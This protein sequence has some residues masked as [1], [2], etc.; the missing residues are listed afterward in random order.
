MS[1]L[2]VKDRAHLNRLTGYLLHVPERAVK[3]RLEEAMPWGPLRLRTAIGDLFG[4]QVHHSRVRVRME[5]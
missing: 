3:F 4:R 1:S 5:G 2:R